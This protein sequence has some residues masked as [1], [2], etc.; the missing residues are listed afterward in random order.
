MLIVAP[1]LL[2]EGRPAIVECRQDV[3]DLLERDRVPPDVHAAL[4]ATL[5]ER[6]GGPVRDHEHAVRKRG[7]AA[8]AT[9]DSHAAVPGARGIRAGAEG[10][11]R[12]VV[13]A[14]RGE[15]AVRLAGALR[16][17]APIRRSP[18]RRNVQLE[19]RR[20]QD[21]GLEGERLRP[22]R[23]EHAVRERD[24]GGRSR[25]EPGPTARHS[26][27]VRHAHQP[28]HADRNDRAPASSGGGTSSTRDPVRRASGNDGRL[29]R[30]GR[31]PSG[32]LPDGPSCR[33]SPRPRRWRARAERPAAQVATDQARTAW[34]S[35]TPPGTARRTTSRCRTRAASTASSTRARIR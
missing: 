20:A 14:R 29:R 9:E 25:A 7:M 17:A 1:T 6:P 4:T 3:D 33:C 12:R 5:P 31:R 11:P 34:C 23:R 32:S 18:T 2:P 15:A 21:R 30:P 22:I 8:R 19:P 24:P 13:Q 16:P 10:R 35:P 27:P 26:H 28:L